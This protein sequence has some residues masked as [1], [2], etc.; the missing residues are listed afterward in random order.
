MP[1][2]VVQDLFLTETA[3]HADV[4]L[5]ACSFVEKDG[6]FTNIEGRVQKFKKAVRAA[7]P[8]QGRTGRSS[9]N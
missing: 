2:L 4:F 9:P 6:S 5:P 1:F 7:R 3:K 8:E